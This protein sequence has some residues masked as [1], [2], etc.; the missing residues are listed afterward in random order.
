VRSDNDTKGRKFFIFKK[1]EWDKVRVILIDLFCKN[2]LVPLFS[3]VLS[4][5][6]DNVYLAYSMEDASD[7]E[8]E[9]AN[10]LIETYPWKANDIT[11]PRVDYSQKATEIVLEMKIVSLSDKEKE[12]YSFG[13]KFNHESI[14]DGMSLCSMSHPETQEPVHEDA[15]LSS[16]SLE[17]IEFDD[18]KDEC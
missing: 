9:F 2:N 8:V 5:D 10:R 4:K 14:S 6:K 12:R 11:V 15:D 7:D 18:G 13:S 1:E 17:T 3:K 16:D